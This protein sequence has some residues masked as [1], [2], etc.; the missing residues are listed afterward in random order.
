MV[1]LPD[2]GQ[3]LLPQRVYT[4][5]RDS[6]FTPRAPVG[7]GCPGFPRGPAEVKYIL[8][9]DILFRKKKKTFKCHYIYYQALVLYI[10]LT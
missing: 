3:S 4:T 2:V 7:P 8:A 10:T 5:P 1:V 9:E 6:P